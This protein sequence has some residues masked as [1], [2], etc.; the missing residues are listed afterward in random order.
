MNSVS[1]NMIGH[2]PALAMA[3]DHLSS[4]ADIDRPILVIGER[5]TGKELAAERLHFLSP[6]WSQAFIKI[7]CGA[8]TESLM[9]SELFGHEAG[10]FTGATKLH[11]GR[12]ERADGG[13]L[14]LDELGTMSLRLQEKLLRL[15][16]YGEFER[17]G[18]H[19]TLSV[20]VRIIAATNADLRR[21]ADA[22][23]F[24]WDLLDRL[25]F[26]VVRLPP[27]R[28]RPEDI[29]ELANHFAI[30]LIS[31]LGWEVFPGFSDAALHELQ[32]HTWLG[33]VRELKNV[34]E[35]SIYRWGRQ[36]DP[37]DRVIIDPYAGYGETSP[38][39]DNDNTYLEA[40][41]T[42][43]PVQPAL[44]QADTQPVSRQALPINLNDTMVNAER[45]WLESA[46]LQSQQQQKDAAELLGLSYNQIRGL[47]RKHG[48][49]TR[50]P[51]G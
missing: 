30:K 2:S 18:G 3:L 39:R 44:P 35:R 1:Q 33:N 41:V 8:I 14:F 28:E 50:R 16:E 37:V 45:M 27:L 25:T 49:R 19:K 34:V 26:D 7:N 38:D 29:L 12:F 48:L 15:I 10:A 5:G 4:L 40:A 17:V 9:E 13:T 24:R 22:G 46:L 20:D 32:R 21:M 36:S 11:V 31:E 6:R 51:R 42:D 43:L 23:K 47:M